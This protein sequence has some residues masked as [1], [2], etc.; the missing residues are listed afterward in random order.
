[1]RSCPAEASIRPSGAKATDFTVPAWPGSWRTSRPVAASQSRTVAWSLPVARSLPSGEK[2]HAEHCAVRLERRRVE[3]SE[4]ALWAAG[5]A[6]HSARTAGPSRPE[7]QRTKRKVATTWVRSAAG[8]GNSRCRGTVSR[9]R[10]T[11]AGGA[12]NTSCPGTNSLLLV[13]TAPIPSAPAYTTPWRPVDQI[14]LNP[15]RPLCQWRGQRLGRSP[16]TAGR[17]G[18]LPRW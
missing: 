18:L 17:R 11:I 9:R 7:A 3:A 4:G 2:A 5:Q 14:D 16:Q 15:A 1:M 8:H 12:I 10:E 13:P 6:V